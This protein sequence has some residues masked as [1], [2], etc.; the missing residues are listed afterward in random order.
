[1]NVI[2][3][4]YGKYFAGEALVLRG[5]DIRPAGDNFEIVFTYN[6]GVNDVEVKLAAVAKGNIDITKKLAAGYVRKINGTLTFVMV[7]DVEPKENQSEQPGTS[8]A[9][10]NAV[11]QHSVYVA[12][13]IIC[14]PAAVALMLFDIN[15][16]L[17]ASA[18]ATSVNTS[19]LQRGIYIVRAAY[20][21]GSVTTVKVAK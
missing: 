18:E 15:G 16:R 12:N 7:S 9:I 2:N 14:A 19:A 10:D 13:D 20:A 3:H 11:A 1:M 17:V 5:A 21:N 8:V 6:D 4:F